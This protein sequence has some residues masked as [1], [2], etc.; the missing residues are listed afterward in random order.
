LALTEFDLGKLKIAAH[1]REEL[2]RAGIAAEAIQC[3]SGG[4]HTRPGTARIIVTVDGIA[5]HVDLSVD[6]VAGCESIVAGEV[7]YKIAAL[8][9]QIKNRPIDTA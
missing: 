9:G 6:E 2:D 7:W 8:I 4:L 5:T 1:V 3:K